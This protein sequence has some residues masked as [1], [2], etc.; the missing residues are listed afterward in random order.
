VTALGVLIRKIRHRFLRFL[1]RNPEPN[2]RCMVCGGRHRVND[3][4]V[5]VGDPERFSL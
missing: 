5:N 3:C 4:P 2:L 1:G